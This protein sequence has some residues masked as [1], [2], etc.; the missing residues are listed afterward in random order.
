MSGF[1]LRSTEERDLPAITAIYG[2]AV[3]TGT[4]SYELEPPALEEMTRRWRELVVRDYPHLVAVRGDNLLGY[5]YAGPYRPRPAYRYSVE[6]S[7]YVAPAAQGAGVGRALL[8]EL[9]AISERLGF[10]QMIAVIGGGT[11][12]PASVGLHAALGFHQIGV[13]EGSGFKH[14]RWLDTV[15]MQRPLGPG[16]STLPDA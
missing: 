5:A 8:A 14:G 16:R 4:A 13:I 2:E 9:I 3:R 1:T 6:D 11:E 7:I 10:R 12:H 15:L